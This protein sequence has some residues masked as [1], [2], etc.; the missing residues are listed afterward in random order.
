MDWWDE[1]LCRRIVERGRRVI[2]YDQRDTG[3]ST[4]DPVG[5]PAYTSSDL[6]GDALAV[7]DAVGVERGHV[8]GLSMGGGVAQRTA[9][10]RPDRIATLTLI[11]T[12]SI[13]PTE[14]LPGPTD[15]V[16]A[17]FA[18]PPPEPDWHDRAAVVEHVVA[19]ERPYAGPGTFDADRVRALVGRVFDRTPDMS[20]AFTNHSLV[21]SAG[22]GEFRFDGLADVPTLVVHG[23][24]DPL[25]PL[26]HGRSLAA[27]ITGARLLELDGV[28]HELPP[29]R[30]WAALVD[31]LVEH[32]G[33]LDRG[34]GCP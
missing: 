26:A 11:S 21:A 20:A 14:D 10:E 13:G 19:G 25:F 12:T 29:P 23:T 18:D 5:F 8:V 32:S 4:H 33:V 27:A 22:D 6:V 34:V 24:E 28:G 1:E 7:L 3:E 17:T 2:R 30:T 15:E 9:L 16:L 31:A